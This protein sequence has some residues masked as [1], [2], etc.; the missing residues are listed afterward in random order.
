MS[1]KVYDNFLEEKDYNKISTLMLSSEFPW[2]MNEILEDGVEGMNVNPLDNLEFT[3]FF[4][5]NYLQQ[6]SYIPLI[7]P[8]IEKIDPKALVRIRAALM[9][10][11]DKIEADAYHVDVDGYNCTTAIYYLNTNNGYTKFEDGSKVES[12]ANR[13]VEFDSNMRHTGSL[14]TDS[15]Y[16]ALI[17]FNYFK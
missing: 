8:L 14:T 3:H 1:I 7:Y 10:K 6:S 12:I 9:V 11:R 4:F 15:K 5:Y 16:R 2:Y 17:N 13:F